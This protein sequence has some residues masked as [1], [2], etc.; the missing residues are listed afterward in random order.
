MTLRRWLAAAFI[1]ILLIAASVPN[2]L[3]WQL[4]KQLG[5]LTGQPVALQ[6]LSFNPFV[7]R[8][9]IEGLEVGSIRVGSLTVH[10]QL[11][12]LFS[13]TVH[14]SHILLEDSR[15]ALEL[16]ETGVIIPGINLP[17]SEEQEATADEPASWQVHVDLVEVSDV[18]IEVAS[19]GVVHPIELKQVRV[20]T[21][22]RLSRQ[23]QYKVEAMLEE[24]ATLSAEGSLELLDNGLAIEGNLDLTSFPLTQ[25]SAEAQIDLAGTLDKL[26]TSYAVRLEDE[27]LQV[28]LD[29]DVSLASIKLTQPV[30]LSLASSS[31]RGPVI[32]EQQQLK[33]EGELQLGGLSLTDIPSIDTATLNGLVWNGLLETPLQQPMKSTVAG[34]VAVTDISLS[35][36]LKLASI[37]VDDFSLLENQTVTM[38]KLGVTGLQAEVLRDEN[39][40]L[41]LLP[42]SSEDVAEAALEPETEQAEP[43][44]TE[45]PWRFAI[46]EVLL[47][48]NSQV[49]YTDRSVT[50][51]VNLKLEQIQFEAKDVQRSNPFPI[52]LSAQHKEG[53]EAEGGLRLAGTA[54]LAD[55]PGADFTLNL[56]GFE[57]HQVGPYLGDGIQRGRLKLDSEVEVN[58]LQVKAANQITIEGLLV[59]EK[60]IQQTTG[61]MPVAM[62]LDLLKDSD[63]VISLSVPVETTFDDF[64][65]GTADIIRRA[66]VSAT[67]KAA[68]T[69]AK[70]ALQPFGAIMLIKDQVDKANRPSFQPIRFS[71]G[72]VELGDDAVNYMGKLVELLNERPKLKLTICG[73]AT[74]QDPTVEEVTRENG[75]VEQK[76]IDLRALALARGNAVRSGLLQ[77]G[78]AEGRIFAC[79]PEV[80]EDESEPRVIL[81]L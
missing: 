34:N 39:G 28:Q 44:E 6:E 74:S 48:G 36:W 21:G 43:S 20:S 9:G 70:F 61:E 33:L 18:T 76:P 46:G 35:S 4:K 14:V 32:L 73:V 66:L 45:S 7:S 81:T 63:D 54:N 5:S 17:A 55:L 59:D 23:L 56:D 25:L 12:P 53:N 11:A 2:I 71:P 69:Y 19:K 68:L 1:L 22:P 79:R 62:A 58:T 10:Y 24:Q 40:V 67:Q 3:G 15:A 27:G 51:A 30:G 57:L 52:Q 64:K 78:I 31:W 47:N 77:G 37:D 75:E 13:N 65:V 49:V 8:L 80:K 29:P 16:T 26:S 60:N 41:N 38:A 50:P 42:D 72:K